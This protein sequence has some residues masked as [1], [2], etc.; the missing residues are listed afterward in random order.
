VSNI[1]IALAQS[2]PSPIVRN[3]AFVVFFAIALTFDLAIFNAA[4]WL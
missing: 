2:K 4:G 1:S 3:V